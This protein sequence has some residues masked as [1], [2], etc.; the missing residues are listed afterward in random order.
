MGHKAG[1]NAECIGWTTSSLWKNKD[2]D[3]GV[4]QCREEE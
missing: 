1:V 4:R 3:Y 2:D